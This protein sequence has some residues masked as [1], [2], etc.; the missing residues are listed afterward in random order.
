[1]V[2]VTAN[3]QILGPSILNFDERGAQYLGE[4]ADKIDND[5]LYQINGNTLGNHYSLTK[6][7]WIRDHQ[8][9]LYERTYK[10]LHWSAFVA[11]M[12]GA[13]AALDFSL[14]N[15]TLLFD[16]EKRTWS[17]ELL[18]VA[19]IERSV[20][21]DTVPSGDVIGQVPDQMATQLSL[22]RG[23][24]I[25]SGT[26][27]QNANAVGCGVIEAGKAVYSMGTFL[28]I[29]P[30]FIE[31]RAPQIMIERGINTEHH[32]VPGQYVCFLY[33]QGGSLVKWYR[34]TFAAAEHA[35][36]EGRGESVY[37]QLLAETPA[38]PSGVLVLPHFT[39]TG[40]PQFISDSCGVI[41]GLR[42]ETQRGEI[43]KGILEGSTF[44][45]KELV[46][47]LPPTG[48]AIDQYIAAGGGSRSDIWLQVCADILGIPFTRSATGEAGA[49]GSA[50][51]AGVGCGVFDSYSEG[52][53]AM[54]RYERTFEPDVIRHNEYAE[55]Y[56]KYQQLWPLLGEYLR[57]L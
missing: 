41:I 47:S 2:P 27:D 35:Q 51:I 55:R 29:T 21:P 49:L 42:L 9:L 33:N 13:E 7:M 54:V 15:R 8:P 45:L 22:P 43:L 37:S 46:D 6:L 48:I 18:Q 25:V 57:N 56:T 20:L 11:Y 50:I 26:H 38:G 24:A 28:C 23:V 31:R 17:D 10:F 34:D 4:L 3:R 5:R 12:L 36:A 44:Y 19:G 53:D 30:V 39:T 1:M 32:A 40:P 52:V 14:A 16:L